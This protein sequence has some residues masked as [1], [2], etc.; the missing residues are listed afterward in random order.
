SDKMKYFI[1]LVFSALSFA[2]LSCSNDAIYKPPDEPKMILEVTNDAEGLFDV[3]GKSLIL[4]LYNNG[5]AEFDEIDQ[6]KRD[7]SKPFQSVDE[8]KVQKHIN[9]TEDEVDHFRELI[10][11]P[12][13]LN[14]DSEYNPSCGFTDT[15]V[16][17]AF[18][19]VVKDGIKEVSIIN[20][21]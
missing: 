13:F 6:T 5:I 20:Y 15:Q 18:R 1:V 19:A 4:R 16:I 8:L 21:C 11:S 9:L 10:D 17:V 7:R 3:T 14:L 2:L 12:S